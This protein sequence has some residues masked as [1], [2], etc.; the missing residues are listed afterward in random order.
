MGLFAH[1][2]MRKHMKELSDLV[3]KGILCMDCSKIGAA[4]NLYYKAA[5]FRKAIHQDIKRRY[6]LDAAEEWDVMSTA[7]LGELA[8]YFARM[9]PKPQN[10]CLDISAGPMLAP[11]QKQPQP[12]EGLGQTIRQILPSAVNAMAFKVSHKPLPH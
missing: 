10:D 9:S 12:A 1:L 8:V 7:E 3:Y 2:A 6:G 11:R 4:E 5:I